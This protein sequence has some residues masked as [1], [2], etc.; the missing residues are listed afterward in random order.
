MSDSLPSVLPLNVSAAS[1]PAALAG[2]PQNQP[3]GA[4]NLFAQLLVAQFKERGLMLGASGALNLTQLVQPLQELPQGGNGLPVTLPVGDDLMQLLQAGAGT[5]ALP[6]T[7]AEP[8]D[9]S[10]GGNLL[11]IALRS[12][13]HAS[14]A[15]KAIAAAPVIDTADTPLTGASTARSNP[16]PLIN[17][18]RTSQRENALLAQMNADTK[19]AGAGVG[20]FMLDPLPELI[21]QKLAAKLNTATPSAT[22]S[23]APA[24]GGLLSPLPGAMAAMSTP[25]ATPSVFVPI[26]HEGWGHEIGDRVRWLVT[27]NIQTA[28]IRLNPP[29]LGPVRVHIAVDQGQVS[30][31]FTSHHSVVR[32]ALQSAMTSL[33]DLLAESGLN[34]AQ[35]NVADQSP[36]HQ[37]ADADDLSEFNLG[38]SEE[39]VVDGISSGI[40][41]R[42]SAISGRGLVDHYV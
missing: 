31:T 25:A 28:D 37:Q 3:L 42:L 20:G 21:A 33:S 41:D 40:P 23:N 38:F 7:S 27:Q 16:S 36:D 18:L 11:D 13:I 35:G 30:V 12:A 15:N 2:T 34:L 9:H 14:S 1:N 19:T 32:E 22:S 10:A 4:Q 17:D 5:E 8:G 6:V 24:M 26:D 39:D 29:E